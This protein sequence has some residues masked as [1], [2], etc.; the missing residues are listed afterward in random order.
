M[1]RKFSALLLVLWLVSSGSLS[2]GAQ[3]TQKDEPL[4]YALVIEE[5]FAGKKV[6]DKPVKALLIENTTRFDDFE[7]EKAV[8]AK[9]AATPM[10]KGLK[11]D[12]M[13]NFIRQN[14]QPTPLTSLIKS[15]LK[16]ERIDGKRAQETVSGEKWKEFYAAYGDSAGIISL[17]KIGF[18]KEGRQALVYVAHV[19]GEDAGRGTILFLQ[20]TGQQWKIQEKVVNWV[21]AG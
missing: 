10:F 5:L 1:I 20:K 11:P 15:S 8:S 17:S 9:A 6:S 4:I 3:T 2:A 13:Q 14:S 7:G 21:W 19:Y 16:L 18:D 12:T